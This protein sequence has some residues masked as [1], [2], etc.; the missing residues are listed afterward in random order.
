[1]TTSKTTRRPGARW[2]VLAAALAFGVAGAATAW[3]L[4]GADRLR[5]G[6]TRVIDTNLVTLAV[7]R[8]D[9]APGRRADRGGAVTSLGDDALVLSGAGRLWT[10]D[11]ATGGVEPLA[12]AAPVSNRAG[13]P[14]LEDKLGVRIRTDRI[15]H[16]DIAYLQR[17]G[18]SLLLIAHMHMN[19]EGECFHMRLSALEVPDTPAAVAA[20][21]AEAQDW[22]TVFTSEP[23]VGVKQKGTPFALHMTGG[24]MAVL[25]DAHVL[26]NVGD[27]Q[28]DGRN[29][30]APW[31]QMDDVDYGKTHRI[32]VDTGAATVFSKGHRNNQGLTVA[33]DG[34]IWALEHGPQGGDEL[35]LLVEGGN[36]GWP[37]ASYGVHYGTKD[38]PLAPAPGRHDQPEFIR[39]IYA[40][41]PS[42]GISHLDA[43]TGF[44]PAWE[45]DLLVGSMAGETVFRLHVREGRVIVA[46]PIQVGARVRYVHQHAAGPIL[47]WTDDEELIVVRPGV[48]RAREA[49]AAARADL[50]PRAEAVFDQC[51]ECHAAGGANAAAPDLEGV[52]GR[53]VARADFP[54]YSQ[55]LKRVG[56]R[57]SEARLDAYLADPQAFAPGGAMVAMG[58]EDDRATR[59]E[60]IALLKAFRVP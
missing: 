52:V 9:F 53:R 5:G 46:E 54:R 48:D 49:L 17:P 7:E 45:G 1:M 36:Y 41:V 42:F 58:L 4:W 22:R 40:W 50:S 20:L 31:A 35:N 8:T 60:I 57:W 29:S 34:R 15:R 24:R 33:D 16:L 25:D 6:A 19:R 43:V 14:P 38:W 28:H 37:Y 3:M 11:L 56:G 47:L 39:P 30:D 18:R 21:V 44:H 51:W 2:A 13:V 55:A 12:I 10:Y 59:A 26:L 27:F 23:C 32:N